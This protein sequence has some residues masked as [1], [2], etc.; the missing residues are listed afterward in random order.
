MDPLIAI[1]LFASNIADDAL[2]VLFVRRTAAGKA[3]QA[4]VISGAL[5]LL[6][7]FSVVNYVEN[8]WYL[9]PII[10]GSMVG[11][12][13]AVT[14]DR[15]YRRKTNAKKRKKA[16]SEEQKNASSAGKKTKSRGKEEGTGQGTSGS[17]CL[18]DPAKDRLDTDAK[19]G[20]VAG[21]NGLQRDSVE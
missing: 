10:L 8:K 3:S 11:C 19:P 13:V 5:T 7:A 1:L 15:A 2:A 16:E 21:S 14:W 17:V 9:I 18:R 20:S 4:A 12:W 6:I